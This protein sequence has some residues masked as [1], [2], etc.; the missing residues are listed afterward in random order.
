MPWGILVSP[1]SYPRLGVRDEIGRGPI[2]R[3]KPAETSRCKH[4][5]SYPIND[6]GLNADRE[7]PGRA[8]QSVP[9]KEDPSSGLSPAPP[10]PRTMPGL[11]V[12]QRLEACCVSGPHHCWDLP[13]KNQGQQAEIE[14]NHA[15][16]CPRPRRIPGP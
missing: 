14:R 2:L 10:E 3:G 11:P 5:K 13:L 16:T 8:V 9:L 4:P 15:P 6:E 7:S 1:I 12:V